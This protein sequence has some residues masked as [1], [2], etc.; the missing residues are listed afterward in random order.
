MIS[1][2]DVIQLLP[3]HVA[4]QIAAG[5][6]VQRPASVVKELIENAVDA[7]ADV[8]SLIVKDA[9]RTLMQVVDNGG[10]MSVTD[11]RMA[12]ERHATS[13]IRATEDIFSIKTKGFRGEAL[14]SIAAVAQVDAVSKRDSDEVATRLIIE[15]G[16]VRDQLPAA[17]KRGTS[18]SVKNLFYNVPAR[19]NFLKSNQVEF[20]HIQDEFLRV[21][22]AHDQIEFNLYHNDAEVYLLKKGNL[23]QRIVQIFGK[24]IESQLVPIAEETEI[25]S[26]KGF[27]GKPES[28]KKARGEQYF[29]VNERFIK[30]NYL[31][32][33]IVDAFEH[34][35][36]TQYVPSYFLYLEI[37]PSKIDI[38]IHPTKTEIKFEDEY[39]IYAV[40]RAAVKHA[41]G[42]Y[43]VTPSLDFDQNPDWAFIPSAATNETIKT[44][45]IKVDRNYN[46][47]ESQTSSYKNI[48]PVQDLYQSFSEFELESNHP[49]MI[50]NKEEFESDEIQAFQWQQKYIVAQFRGELLVIDQHRAHSLILFEQLK[51]SGEENALSQRLLFPVEIISNPGEINQL[52]NIEN[53]LLRFGFDVEFSEDQILVNALPTEIE[54]D[55]VPSIFSDF[56]TDLELHDKINFNTEIAKILAK[57]AAIRK[58]E[59]LQPEQARHL[60]QQL[61]QLDE[62]NF[63]PYGKPVFV[64]F[65]ESEILKKLN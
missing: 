61:L 56:L 42:Q 22:L 14:A 36:P 57:N 1:M 58:G 21:A 27:V 52:K 32:K 12:F 25:V 40:L 20:R 16:E 7:K 33:A 23:K 31:H 30:N 29:F 53:D 62:P 34:L 44:P 46:P 48:Q 13:K 47:F 49:A 64:Q 2:E 28:A 51:K 5:E 19:R 37:D 45:E 39:A 11:V 9:G 60:A 35:L 26:V 24:K 59:N 55:D 18:I 3:D 15:G 6:V 63:S 8:I 17:A 41:L 50:L 43:N 65:S 4:N 38:N 10:G 54:P